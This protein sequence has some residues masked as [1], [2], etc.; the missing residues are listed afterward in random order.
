MLFDS[1]KEVKLSLIKVLE[2]VEIPA[3]QAMQFIQA[4]F[5]PNTFSKL[6]IKRNQ[7]LMRVLALRMDADTV[8]E[9]LNVMQGQ[10]SSPLV[11]EHFGE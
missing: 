9:Y 10:F 4:I 2:Q 6:P 5:G 3:E 1:A 8:D 11:N 7:D